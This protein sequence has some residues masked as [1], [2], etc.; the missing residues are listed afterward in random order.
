MDAIPM[1]GLFPPSVYELTYRMLEHAV[2]AEM[3]HLVIINVTESAGT[4]QL[5]VDQCV[6]LAEGILITSSESLRWPPAD[7]D[8]RLLTT[9]A[10]RGLADCGERIAHTGPPAE[11]GPRAVY[12][13]LSR[14]VAA[15]EPATYVFPPGESFILPVWTTAAILVTF[16]PGHPWQELLK[17]IWSQT[18]DDGLNSS[19]ISALCCRSRRRQFRTHTG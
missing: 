17:Q 15:G 2:R 6:A 13:Y 8:I 9:V 5:I 3:A 16:R 1:P 14:V 18:T 19:A 11:A 12:A 10:I 7:E 4:C